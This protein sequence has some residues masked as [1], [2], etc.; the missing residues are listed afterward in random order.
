MKRKIL[1][2]SECI[3]IIMLVICCFCKTSNAI[4]TGT[5]YLE[6]NKNIFEQGEEIEIKVAI[7]NT[8]TVS[9]TTNLYFDNYKL[10]YISGPENTNVVD[11]RVIYVW[12][13]ITGGSSPKDGELAVFRFRAKENGIATF[14]LDGEFYDSERQVIQTEFRD[15]QIQIGK[16]E[17]EV[18]G[19]ENSNQQLDSKSDNSTLQVLRLD[20]EGIIPD[21]DKNIYDYYL[22]VGND[23]NDI[24]V[25][26]ISENP[27][28]KIEIVGN[29]NLKE[30]LNN[31]IIKVTS[32]D[33]TQNK[34][35][36]IQVTKTN[37][38]EL[39]NTNLEILAIENILLNPPFDANITHYSIEV[40]NDVTNLNIFAVPQNENAKV[41]IIGKDNLKEGNNSISVI[42]TAQNGFSKRVY[43]INCYKRN[44]EEQSKYEQEQEE[45]KKKLEE[46]YEAERVDNKDDIFNKNNIIKVILITL[47]SIAII[48]V[49]AVCWGKHLRLN[50]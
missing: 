41:E 35:Y 24:D 22:T 16:E 20:K 49:I 42:V 40:P 13:D 7:E 32:E 26:A 38:I 21:F 29:N 14:N 43:E 39:A 44:Q 50:K 6:S 33:E 15:V 30:G 5:V 18:E 31:I 25:L 17:I 37:N 3:L 23:I 27:N 10:E 45:N 48:I 46:I 47:L 4:N 19:Q 9:F 2:I 11:N 36:T 12:Y 28:A 1:V 34:V 8:K